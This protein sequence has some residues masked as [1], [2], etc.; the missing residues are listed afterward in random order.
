ML[1]ALTPPQFYSPCWLKRFTRARSAAGASRAAAGSS[2]SLA[3]RSIYCWCSSR[4]RCCWLLTLLLAAHAAAGCSRCCWLITLLLA[5]QLRSSAAGIPS[6][7]NSA[8]LALALLL[9]LRSC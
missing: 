1:L 8:S 9:P 4:W 7:S 6:A 2:T 3:L 5:L